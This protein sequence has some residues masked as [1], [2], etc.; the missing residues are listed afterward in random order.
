ML[1]RSVQ[2]TFLKSFCSESYQS[3]LRWLYET[4]RKTYGMIQT[5]KRCCSLIK[6]RSFDEQEKFGKSTHVKP[7]VIGCSLFRSCTSVLSNTLEL[8]EIVLSRTARPNTDRNE[9]GVGNSII[10]SFPFCHRP[11]EQIKRSNYRGLEEKRYMWQ[12]ICM[13]PTRHH[14]LCYTYRTTLPVPIG[15]TTA[16]LFRNWFKRQ[17]NLQTSTIADISMGDA[18]NDGDN[19][20]D[21]RGQGGVKI[22]GI[23]EQSRRDVSCTDE[24]CGYG[25][26]NLWRNIV[27]SLRSKRFCENLKKWQRKY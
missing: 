3:Q 2:L 16:L 22:D 27:I 6:V 24:K 7:F 23:K 21:L 1:V 5:L 10:S 8:E 13:S 17:S 12:T 9:G 19:A 15:Q 18:K 25:R 11:K 26:C 14:R 20:N 4:K